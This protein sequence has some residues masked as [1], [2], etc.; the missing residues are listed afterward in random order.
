MR[1]AVKNR[2]RRLDFEPLED[3]RLLSVGSFPVPLEGEAPPGSLIYGSSASATID[4]VG[5]V[6]I[7]TLDLDDGQAVTCDDFVAAMADA[8][9]R[10]FSQFKRWYS[11]AGTPEVEMSQSWSERGELELTLRQHTPATPGQPEKLPFHI[12]VLV[13][14]LAPD[15]RDMA[16]DRIANGMYIYKVVVKSDSG[17]KELV[18]RLAKIE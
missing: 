12:P 2:L 7:Y 8:S 13:G 11:Q 5:E 15:G 9:G 6:D 17:E 1:T 14:F 16:G 4:Y 18:G 10:D 3:R